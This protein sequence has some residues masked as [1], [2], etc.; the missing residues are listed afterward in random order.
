MDNLLKSVFDLPDVSFIDNDGIQDMMERLVKNYE[1]KYKEETGQT[2]SLSKADPIR[3]LLYAVALDLYQVE[4]YVD[5]AG[6]QDLLKYSYGAFLDNLAA[7]RGVKRMQPSAAQTTIRFT[8]SETKNYVVGIPA[9]TRVTNGNGLYFETEK[10]AEIKP[11]SSY[12]D[13][14]AVCTITGVQG[15]EALPGQIN[16]LSDP[17]PY[18]KSVSNITTSEGGAE[19]ESDES[20]AERVYLAPSK[21]S[22]AGP[23][24]AYIYWARTYNAA[25]GSVRPTSPEAGEAVIYVLMRDG[26]MPGTEILTGL[27]E[28]LSQNQ[29]RPMTDNVSVKAPEAVSFD[30]NIKYFINQSSAAASASIQREVER[31]ISEYIS[32]QTTV[33]GRDINPDELCERIKA[34]GAKRVEITAPTFTVVGDES[35]AQLSEKTAIYGGL[36]ND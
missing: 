25:I 29:I 1:T 23:E 15:N 5:R 21:Y 4:Q 2:I 11:G 7:N 6:K 33:I 16:I 26:T 22:V 18:I 34:A 36:E 10:Y 17:L 14:E 8:L 20:L 13:V 24:D 35:V 12:A 9:G 31:A 32:W 28:Y 27:Q 30:I 19:L 3:I